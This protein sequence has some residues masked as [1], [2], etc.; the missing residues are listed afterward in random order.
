MNVAL[1]DLWNNVTQS[2][3]NGIPF[4]SLAFPNK[5]YGDSLKLK[6]YV[7]LKSVYH[8]CPHDGSH[9][10]TLVSEPFTRAYS[11]L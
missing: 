7:I 9:V 5:E 1:L 8:H 11:A 4:V 10:P 2:T 6:V 3:S